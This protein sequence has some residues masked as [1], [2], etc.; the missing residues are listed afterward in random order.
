MRR[1]GAPAATGRRGVLVDGGLTA[2]VAGV[3]A[4]V[5]VPPLARAT[6]VVYGY[7]DWAAHAYRVRFL[8]AHGLVNWDPDWDAGMP[9]F[10]GYQTLP[11]VLTAA[12]DGVTR[13]GIPRSMLVWDMALM[14]ALP[15][16][17]YLALRLLGC[18]RAGALLGAA[19]LLDDLAM[20]KAAG[21]FAFMFGLALVPLL[22]WA[23]LRGFGARGGWLGA[24]ALG[25][26]PYLHLYATLGALLVLAAR[27]AYDRSRP[28]ARLLL[29]IG[30]AVVIAAFLWLPVLHTA[31]PVYVNP[32]LAD[33]GE[34]R[35][36]L[37]TSGI[38]GFSVGVVA[39]SVLALVAVPWLP[40]AAR[41]QVVCC[42]G[43]AA[44]GCVLMALA[45][46]GWL[47]R[48]LQEAQ[49]TRLTPALGAVA[50]MGAA[51]AGD[52]LPD[53]LRRA[54]ARARLGVPARLPAAAL[55][56]LLVLAVAEGRHWYDA[57]QTAYLPV[58]DGPPAGRALAAFAAADGLPP[59]AEVWDSSNDL[60]FTSY[61]A[62]GAFHFTGDYVMGD[63]WGAPSQR[64]LQLLQF[65]D[66]GSPGQT[67]DFSPIERY[68]RLYGV[69]LLYLS[70]AN[71]VTRDVAVG[72]LAGHLGR[73]VPVDGGWIATVPWDPVGAFAAPAAEVRATT[74]PDIAYDTD[75]ELA[76]E[77][78]L[79]GAFDAVA[80]GRHA[81]RAQ[82]AFSD[83]THA[84]ATLDAA[85][86]ELLVVP[87]NWDT[88]WHAAVDGS[89]VPVERVGPGFLAVDLGPRRG[90]V[91]VA[92]EHAPYWTW[93]L[94]LGL[95]GAG[96]AA[97]LA[98]AALDPA[99]A[100]RPRRRT[101][102]PAGGA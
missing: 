101:G 28:S 50:A 7:G 51:P 52:A 10:Q 38:G 54:A 53:L 85:P 41:S 78:A 61:A 23:A 34:A 25:L 42:T 57:G 74:M 69:R 81:A 70:A 44:A 97:A 67:G 4:A 90:P 26:S 40:A 19:L 102:A 43:A 99:V 32:L 31:R 72:R 64:L 11:H 65:A 87:V 71:P 77:D 36:L 91:T 16:V 73:V 20:T 29:Q 92:L 62:F 6:W 13:L 58:G 66:P 39:V 5:V 79:A 3:A 55:A 75:V 15:A 96:V 84:T 8:E 22:V 45:W 83:P 60:A 93:E 100:E 76:R 21:D 94:G 30:L 24:I 33:V 1:S 59:G 88:V 18:G 46:E 48:L 95:S 12:L 17:G 82:L 86:G 35:R 37:I 80:G 9:L 98:A 89:E 56:V 49:L 47:P 63:A 27:L 2:A 68:L 14:C